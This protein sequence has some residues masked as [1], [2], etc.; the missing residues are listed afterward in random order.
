MDYCRHRRT[1]IESVGLFT[2]IKEKLLSAG[3]PVSIAMFNTLFE[4]SDFYHNIRLTCTIVCFLHCTRLWLIFRH[5][6]FLIAIFWHW[7]CHI[8]LSSPVSSLQ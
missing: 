2:V 4:V 7:I 1:L 6:G 8:R 3:E 5:E